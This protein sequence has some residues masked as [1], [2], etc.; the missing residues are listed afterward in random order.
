MF[1]PLYGPYIEMQRLHESDESFGARAW[2][3]VHIGTAIGAHLIFGFRHIS[4]VA[5]ATGTGSFFN[6]KSVERMQRIFAMGTS[7][8]FYGAYA[9]GALVVGHQKAKKKLQKERGYSANPFAY[10]T[11]YSSG[12]GPVV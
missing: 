7:P 3:A 8:L 10:T 12:F 2:D 5:A 11:P 1:I 9:T 6:V 4:H